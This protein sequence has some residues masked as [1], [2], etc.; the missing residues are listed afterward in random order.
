MEEPGA[1]RG[2]FKQSGTRR[3]T[4][5]RYSVAL[6]LRCFSRERFWSAISISNSHKTLAPQRPLE[7]LCCVHLVLRMKSWDLGINWVS[8]RKVCILFSASL[9]L[10]S[11]V[12]FGYGYNKHRSLRDYNPDSASYSATTSVTSWSWVHCSVNW[13]LPWWLSVWTNEKHLTASVSDILRSLFWAQFPHLSSE[14]SPKEWLFKAAC[15]TP[16]AEG[17]LNQCS[18]DD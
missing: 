3:A 13:G 6:I 4:L 11:S 10:W 7:M 17:R 15:I 12:C 1:S 16:A 8:M 18:L 14:G 9:R 2:G 5:W